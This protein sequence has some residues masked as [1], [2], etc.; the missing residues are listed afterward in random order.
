M[1]WWCWSDNHPLVGCSI[2]ELFAGASA[3][4]LAAEAHCPKVVRSSPLTSL[5]AATASTM[6][7]PAGNEL[8]A[9]K[10]KHPTAQRW[11]LLMV[12]FPCQLHTIGGLLP[13]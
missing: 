13:Y 10:A 1:C 7:L 12:L 2:V 8:F 3:Q 9:A 5:D 4:G 11:L 6:L